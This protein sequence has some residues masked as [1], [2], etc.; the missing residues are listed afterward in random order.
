MYNNKWLKIT[1]F[2]TD[3]KGNEYEAAILIKKRDIEYVWQDANNGVIIHTDS[4]FK[5]RV[6]ESIDEIK[7]ELS[8][9][10]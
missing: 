2:Q 1:S 10:D 4:K 7:R 3:D 9:E 8:K 5:I 6:K